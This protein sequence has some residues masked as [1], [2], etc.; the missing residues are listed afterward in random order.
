MID[1][2]LKVY[3]DILNSKQILSIQKVLL[4]EEIPWHFTEKTVQL[5]EN[6]LQKDQSSYEHFMFV[7]RFKDDFGNAISNYCGISDYILKKFVEHTQI[8]IKNNYRV[9]MNLQ[10]KY[11]KIGYN[12]P[13]YDIINKHHWVLIYY[14]CDSD[15]DTF[16]FQDNDQTVRIHPKEGRYILFD[17]SQKHAGSHPVNSDKRIVIN[18]NLDID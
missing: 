14:V 10:T 4:S 7:H 18:Y 16:I 12:T 15:G 8:K 2:K 13:H 1:F 17:G 9:K 3:D 6:G 11:D 5:N